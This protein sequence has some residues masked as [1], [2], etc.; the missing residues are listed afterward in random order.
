MDTPSLTPNPVPPARS[1][2][3]PRARG[4]HPAAGG[5]QLGAV[6]GPD[7]DKSAGAR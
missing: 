2:P 7:G 6:L 4:A 5:R 3:S 1:L